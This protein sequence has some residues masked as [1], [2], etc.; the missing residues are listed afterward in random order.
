MKRPG[1]GYANYGQP[2]KKHKHDHSQRKHHNS[3]GH[4]SSQQS[5]Y[6]TKHNDQD[7]EYQ[8]NSPKPFNHDAIAQ[9][10]LPT[11]KPGQAP[12]YTPFMV[13]SGLPSLPPIQSPSLAQAPFTH[14]S[15]TSYNRSTATST[16]TPDITYERLEFLGDAYIEVIAS[17]LIF[18]R[19]IH[20]TAGQQSQL[21]EV[22]VKNETLAEY[23]RAYGFEE[24]V[25][26]GSMEI[27]HEDSRAKGNKGWNKVLG[28]VFEAYV[29]AVVLAD[30]D[31][32]FSVAE[33]WLTA[34]WAPKLVEAMKKDR[35][36][37]LPSESSLTHDD[38]KVDKSRVY[39]PTAKQELQKRILAPK[40]V[41]LSYEKYKDSV[42][43]KGD[44]LGQNRHFI[45]LYLTGYG[46]DRKLLGQGEGKNKVEAGNWAA[47]EAMHGKGTDVVEE[48]EG[49]LRV[50]KEGRKKEMD[51]K[52]DA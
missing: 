6:G 41:I 7:R 51:P 26:A 9:L 29:A 1:E 22:L 35:S 11:S 16:S 18:S 38:E 52:G 37:G 36:Y 17:R 43:L 5:Q 13:S 10:P 32:G 12:A 45:A 31:E 30:E 40:G 25:K 47:T 49:K 50:M 46:Y 21:R 34:L 15:T 24:R 23:S 27:T 8:Y 20:L 14:K 3:N 39:D 19:F 4:S 2:Y 42:E 33:K 44:Q 28:D 48:C